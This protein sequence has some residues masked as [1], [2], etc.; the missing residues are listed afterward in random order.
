MPVLHH[1]G[2]HTLTF[3]FQPHIVRQ[4][5]LSYQ[6][7]RW[8]THNF[9]RPHLRHLPQ[10]RF[11]TTSVPRDTMT[12]CPL[13]T[14]VSLSSCTLTMPR[15]SGAHLARPSS[16]FHSRLFKPRFIAWHAQLPPSHSSIPP[17]LPSL[18]RLC[19]RCGL[20]V[21]CGVRCT[22]NPNWDES[23]A[24]HP[25]NFHPKTIF[26]PNLKPKPHT[27]EPLNPQPSTLPGTPEHLNT[28]TPKHPNTQTPEH[29]NT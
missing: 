9:W 26:T 2:N 4:L 20:H 3:M 6:F 21:S 25:Q 15:L 22:F 28:Q 8:V 19:S 1:V 13:S 17:P 29:V 23:V 11:P 12:M 10:H 18:V 24:F 16:L 5:F 14:T 7:L 27:P